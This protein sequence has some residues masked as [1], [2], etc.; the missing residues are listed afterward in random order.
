MI[1]P[2]RSKRLFANRAEVIVVAATV[3]IGACVAL[4]ISL[5][6]GYLKRVPIS[7][8]DVPVPIAFVRVSK[9]VFATLLTDGSHW[10]TVSN[11][12]GRLVTYLW[13]DWGPAQRSN[14]Y[15]T[16]EG[17]LAVL[18]AGDLVALIE[19][20]QDG[21][22]R[23]VPWS[24]RSAINTE[25]S[26]SWLYVGAVDGGRAARFISPTLTECVPSFGIVQIY[27]Q[28]HVSR[29]CASEDLRRLESQSAV[30]P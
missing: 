23:P 20:P 29:S 30:E 3:V 25:R 15:I 12:H 1:E 13:E 6:V 2:L 18:G 21:P 27:R 9:Q 10:L 19:M 26:E 11:Q 4:W 5:W 24:E 16:E 22:P 28:T 8:V 17:W 7:D 14:Y